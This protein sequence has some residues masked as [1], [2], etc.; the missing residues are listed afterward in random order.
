ML[1]NHVGP[2]DIM[3][4]DLLVSSPM[5]SSSLMRK[6]TTCGLT[7][8][9]MKWLTLNISASRVMGIS[10]STEPSIH[11]CGEGFHGTASPVL[12][13][14]ARS[15]AAVKIHGTEQDAALGN[16]RFSNNSRDGACLHGRPYEN[17]RR[18][19]VIE[20]PWKLVETST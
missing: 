4:L 9:T 20:Q 2:G 13:S 12:G 16:V 7:C 17:I 19:D 10:L 6:G 5:A 18:G 3:S 8:D 15:E 11:R 1:L 14:L